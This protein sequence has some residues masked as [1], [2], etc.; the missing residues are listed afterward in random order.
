[1]P[2]TDDLPDHVR[3][4]HCGLYFEDFGPLDGPCIDGGQPDEH[5]H[6]PNGA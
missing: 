5:P 3:R 6:Q 2:L 1:M 4:T